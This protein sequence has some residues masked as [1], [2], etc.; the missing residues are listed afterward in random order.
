MKLKRATH[1]NKKYG[2]AP[3]K[4]VL[5]LAVIEQIEA[6]N[7]TDNQIFITADLV[8]AFQKIWLK[9]VPHEGWQ[10][11]FFL[12]F[13]HLSGDGFWH[14]KMA[15]GAEVALTGSYSPKSISAL[16]DSILFA[17]VDDWLWQKLSIPGERRQIR[18]LI[19]QT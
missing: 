17:Y 12:P 7:I 10:P 15:E 5:L 11:R 8:A 16:K 9:L 18:T 19:L 4:P 1:R 2:K 13:Y 6:G 3:H 14:L